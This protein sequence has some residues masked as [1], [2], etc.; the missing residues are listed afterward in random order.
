MAL[1]PSR[2]SSEPEIFYGRELNAA[3]RTEGEALGYKACGDVG[4]HGFWKRWRTT[5]FDVQIY[6]TDAKSYGNRTPKKVLESAVLRKKSKYHE[7][8]CL[9][10]RRDFTFTP[11]LYSVDGMAD[12]HARAAKKRI[13]G[14][15]AAKL[16]R[17]YIQ[18]ASF[19]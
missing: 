8:A 4:A 3:Q 7:E 5:M 19:V 6:D 1:T 9:E 18:M 15:L 2:I 10:R 14:I 12:K 16:T 17:Q 11:M 13:T